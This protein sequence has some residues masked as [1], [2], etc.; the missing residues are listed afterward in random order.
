[1]G[2]TKKFACLKTRWR[3]WCKTNRMLEPT[4]SPIIAATVTLLLLVPV[5][6]AVI[7]NNL[8]LTVSREDDIR[9]HMS[10]RLISAPDERPAVFNLGGSSLLRAVDEDH[11]LEQEFNNQFQFYNL[12][13]PSQ[14]NVESLIL[15][16][17]IDLRAH[18]LVVMH[19][20]IS[21]LNTLSPLKHWICNPYFYTI[22]PGDIIAV[23]N[24]IGVPTEANPMCHI[25]WL[26]RHKL[27]KRMARNLLLGDEA[28]MYAG[29]Y[30]LPLDR[31][32]E[33]LE[34]RRADR[35]AKQA[36]P[37]F[38][39]SWLV[40]HQEKAEANIEL[41]KRMHDYVQRRGAQFV[42]IDLPMNRDWFLQYHGD[43][44]PFEQAYHELFESVRPTGIDYRDLRNMPGYSD[45]DFYD[46]THMIE[47][48]R[49]KFLP[50]YKAIVLEKF[51]ES[52]QP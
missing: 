52:R 11:A 3:A 16:Q 31:D 15:L 29:I 38:N 6:R 30:P 32:R 20:N 35:L 2:I 39:D 24:E 37:K 47:Q 8:H 18:D 22:N 5:T 33:A 23:L 49:K 27:L 26:S 9:A 44:F 17:S 46:H 10:I 45:E 14:S 51:Q 19:V 50:T 48:A 12:T 36:D 42:L 43:W 40:L 28:P 25:T 41:I 34:L 1:M 21:R 4:L 13:T 7:S